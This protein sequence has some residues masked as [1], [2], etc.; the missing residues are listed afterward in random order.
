MPKTVRAEDLILELIEDQLRGAIL[1]R[2]DLIEDDLLLL[3]PLPL[4]ERA[5]GCDIKDHV[6]RAPSIA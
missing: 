6:Q 5:M 2:M 3:R 1:I 4:G